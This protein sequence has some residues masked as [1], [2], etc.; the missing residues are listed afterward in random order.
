MLIRA[1]DDANF[2]TLASKTYEQLLDIAQLAKNFHEEVF[3]QFRNWTPLSKQYKAL[4]A[5]LERLEQ[6]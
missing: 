2:M 5:A 6:E 1:D 3:C 4:H